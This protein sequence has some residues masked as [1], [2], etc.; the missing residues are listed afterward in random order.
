MTFECDTTWVCLLHKVWV[1]YPDAMRFIQGVS[2]RQLLK[3]SWKHSKSCCLKLNLVLT[4]IPAVVFRMKRTLQFIQLDPL[5]RKFQ[6]NHIS[7]DLC[8]VLNLKLHFSSPIMSQHCQNA[9]LAKAS[10]HRIST[11]Q[12]FELA[13]VGPDS[14]LAVKHGT[15]RHWP[16]SV[17]SLRGLARHTALLFSSV[18][19]LAG[20]PSGLVQKMLPS[21][22]L[23]NPLQVSLLWVG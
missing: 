22:I 10:V 9:W 23:N 6:V 2:Q 3:Q 14:Y 11:T 17:Q 4:S 16:E 18:S 5:W 15:R 20:P 8:R 19:V 21:H 7:W 12:H 1:S 13:T